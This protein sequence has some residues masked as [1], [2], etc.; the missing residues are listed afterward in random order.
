MTLN[1]LCLSNEVIPLAH[2]NAL[3]VAFCCLLKTMTAHSF[4]ITLSYFA[5]AKHTSTLLIPVWSVLLPVLCWS[6][7]RPTSSTVS[8]KTLHIPRHQTHRRDRTQYLSLLIRCFLVSKSCTNA[9]KFP[10]LMQTFHNSVLKGVFCLH[11]QNS[12]QE[13]KT[14]FKN[15]SVNSGGL[16]DGERTKGWKRNGIWLQRPL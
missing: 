2:T 14:A 1:I 13:K 9:I 7:C 16:E 15:L 8:A 6:M 11:D 3:F 4:C 10:F 12:S 5:S